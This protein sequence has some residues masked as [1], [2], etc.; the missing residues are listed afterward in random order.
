MSIVGKER[1]EFDG[2]ALVMLSAVRLSL[3]G[4]VFVF[5][6]AFRNPGSEVVF[7]VQNIL[8]FSVYFLCSS[9]AILDH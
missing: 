5:W 8:L 7:G 9:A 4:F 3:L 6:I 2:T 1:H